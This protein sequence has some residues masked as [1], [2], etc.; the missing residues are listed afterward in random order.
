MDKKIS[1]FPLNNYIKTIHFKTTNIISD[2]RGMDKSFPT[3]IYYLYVNL[4]KYLFFFFP[5]FKPP[6]ISCIHRITGCVH[7]ISDITVGAKIS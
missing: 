3:L 6:N 2:L 4:V 5:F 1:I 7:N